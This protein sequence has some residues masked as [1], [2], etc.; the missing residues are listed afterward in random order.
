MSL[1]QMQV[2]LVQWKCKINLIPCNPISGRDFKPSNDHNLNRFESL[3]R[4]KGFR[5]TV[6]KTRGDDI[7]AACGQLA[8]TALK[9]NKTISK[10][11]VVSSTD[12]GI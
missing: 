5:V 11:P 6:R 7:N 3:L 1:Q 8:N 2:N 10:I 9:T 12:T 4:K